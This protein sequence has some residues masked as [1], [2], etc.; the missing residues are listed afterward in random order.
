MKKK[1]VILI[2]H[3]GN[4]GAE[5]VS[6]NLANGLAV[7]GHEVHAVIFHRVK[8]EYELDHDV[9]IHYLERENN[10]KNSVVRKILRLKRVLKEIGPDCVIELGFAIKYILVGGLINK[11][12]YIFSF[13][14]DPE[15]WKKNTKSIF[16]YF[17]NYY[18]GKAR[19]I[20]FQTED[21]RNYFKPY[22][23]KKGV[24]IPNMIKND[25]PEAYKGDRKRE[26]VTF[27]RLNKKKICHY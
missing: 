25:L 16:K 11:Y 1:I 26:V 10:S 9:N 8:A 24:I 21:A 22:I 17:R 3:L 12:N 23:R 6:V 14:N 19:F 18:Y 5:R 15:M 2:A 20:V 7:K 27:C 13:R 4:G